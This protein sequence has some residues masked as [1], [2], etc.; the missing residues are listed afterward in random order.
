MGTGGRM[1]RMLATMLRSAV[2]VAFAVAAASAFTSLPAVGV[3]QRTRLVCAAEPDASTKTPG[4]IAIEAGRNLAS[5]IRTRFRGAPQGPDVDAAVAVASFNSSDPIASLRAVL[6][7]SDPMES[8]KHGLQAELQK[9]GAQLSKQAAEQKEGFVAMLQT[10]VEDLQ[11]EVAAAGENMTAEVKEVAKGLRLV[12]DTASSTASNTT[13]FKR[14]KRDVA[15]QLLRDAVIG[16]PD[17]N[18]ARAGRA[19]G[20]QRARI[21]DLIAPSANQHDIDDAASKAPAQSMHESVQFVKEETAAALDRIKQFAAQ[22]EREKEKKSTG[23]GV[24]EAPEASAVRNDITATKS[25]LGGAGELVSGS[26]TNL[27][28]AAQRSSITTRTDAKTT[29]QTQGKE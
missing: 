24:E 5:R 26:R 4:E 27:R 25:R 12:N 19:L 13:M 22:G 15:Y 23:D 16:R 9:Q 3:V 7:S 6:N 10:A 1:V 29:R 14:R 28:Q 11:K 20:T 8:L 2:V 17:G 18:R 21:A